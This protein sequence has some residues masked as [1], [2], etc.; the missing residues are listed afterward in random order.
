MYTQNTNQRVSKASDF[1]RLN[2]RNDRAQSQ[3]WF[4][5]DESAI[6]SNST[7]LDSVAVSPRDLIGKSNHVDVVYRTMVKP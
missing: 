3:V 2:S 1:P 5:A 7:S 6:L 4:Q